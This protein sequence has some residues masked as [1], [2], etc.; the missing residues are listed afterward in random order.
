MIRWSWHT[1][2][3]H[4]LLHS[5]WL[6]FLAQQAS[7]CCLSFE[8]WGW[9]RVMADTVLELRWL[10]DLL[11][12][13]GVS[14]EYLYSHVLWY[15][16]RHYYRIHFCILWSH[17]IHWSRLPYYSPG[18][19]E[20]HDLFSLYSLGSS[21][22]DLFTKAQISHQFRYV[23]S[24]LSVFDPPWILRVGVNIH[25]YELYIFS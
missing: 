17:K 13:M 1:L 14:C 19:W 5:P 15:Q 23:L 16:E 21:L 10:R 24:K 18:I 7:I 12:D 11:H 9:I 6:H 4:K 3:H 20:M 2:L 8:Y 22:S 25:V